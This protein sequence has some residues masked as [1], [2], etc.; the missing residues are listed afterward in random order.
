MPVNNRTHHHSG[1]STSSYGSPEE[2]AGDP[3]GPSAAWRRSISRSALIGSGAAVW[4]HTEGPLPWRL[5]SL[6]AGGVNGVRSASRRGLSGWFDRFGG[7]RYQPQPPGSI[8]S[9]HAVTQS[10][11]TA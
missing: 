1:P 11:H 4:L 2:A 3:V 9:I 10:I 7:K 6:V 8:R 5:W